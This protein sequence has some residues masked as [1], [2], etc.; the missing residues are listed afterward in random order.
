MLRKENKSCTIFL[1]SIFKELSVKLKWKSE[2]IKI[3]FKI[4]SRSR[5]KLLSR[6]FVIKILTR[7]NTVLHYDV[8][9]GFQRVCCGM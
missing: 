7:P 8:E 3:C 5:E 2:Q 4:G 9:N 6:Y 1:E